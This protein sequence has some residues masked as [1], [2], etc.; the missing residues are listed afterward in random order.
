MKSK[1]LKLLLLLLAM[2]LVLSFGLTAC[3]DPEEPDD[4]DGDTDEPSD[5]TYPEDD[6]PLEGLVLIKKN[7]AQFKVVIASG[8]GSEGRRAAKDL[9]DRLRELG[10]EIADTV[11]DKDAAAVSDCEIIVGVGVRN[12]PDACV[13]EAAE[14][15]PDGSTIRVVGNRVV[16]AGGTI[17]NTRKAVDKLMRVYMGITETTTSKRNVALATDLNDTVLTDYQ[18]DKITVVGNLLSDY[19]IV[20][21]EN[22]FGAY[23][24]VT[25]SVKKAIFNCSGY[26]LPVVDQKNTVDTDKKLIVRTAT[27]A[28]D[29]GFRVFV[30]GENL[31]IECSIHKLF[32]DTAAEFLAKEITSKKGEVSFASDYTWSTHIRTI[33]YADFGAKG[34]GK[35]GDFAAMIACHERA[36]ET[37]QTVVAKGTVGNK[38]YIGKI[39]DP[40]IS[41]KVTDEERTYG[42]QITVKSNCDFTGAEFIIDDTVAGI[43][44]EQRRNRAIFSLTSDKR[45]V[46]YSSEPDATNQI[47]SL[48]ENLSLKAGAKEIPWL[49]SQ[50]VG[51]D[52]FVFIENSNHKDYV[53][54]GGNA[55]NGYNRMEALIVHAG[56][57]ISDETPVTA[58]FDKITEVMWRSVDDTPITFKGGKFTTKSNKTASG[59]AAVYDAYQRGIKINRAN[60]T[61]QDIDHVITGEPG[62]N[63]T[64]YPYYGFVQFYYAYNSTLRDSC[65][66]RHKTYYSPDGVP[67][68]NYDLIIDYSVGIT[69][70]NVE[71]HGDIKDMAYWGISA[72]NGSRN[73]K[74]NK[75]VISRIDAHRGLYNL[76]IKDSTIG[77]AINVIGG[78]TVNIT[79]TVRRVGNNFITL[80]GDYGATFNGTMNIKNCTL[81]AWT[82]KSQTARESVAYIIYSEYNSAH[83]NHNFGYTCYM[84]QYVN[85]DNFKCSAGT[86]YVFPGISD[87]VFG[88]YK[89]CKKITFKNMTKYANAPAGYS[90]LNAISRG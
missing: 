25:D 17:T 81:D 75:V 79:N 70:D 21:D 67:M 72:S 59:K 6:I 16:C 50:L 38:F 36:N 45:G 56:G 77:F 46:T 10:V 68:G 22:D 58:N 40:D 33:S 31:I 42:I 64:S 4:P 44:Y 55:D 76:D 35:D 52:Y 19:K 23:P 2:T 90:K 83:A 12:R 41:D 1:L 89:I 61:V 5:P 32:L 7:V 73:M 51:G 3:A 48:G 63:N 71:Q 69:V 60:A 86:T 84:P 28:G 8:A 47:S 9:V 80:R 49:A 11:E 18:V 57:I 85:L 24:Y 15:G 27:N 88:K 87:S 54:Y 13:M 20:C 30:E 29:D 74:F 62:G 37:G 34:D 65:L 66:N 14:F 78:G 26:N 43:H 82:N 53:R 39:W